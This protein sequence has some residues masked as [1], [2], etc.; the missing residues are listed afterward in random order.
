MKNASLGR[1]STPTPSRLRHEGR[2]D[3]VSRY[4][5]RQSLVLYPA[6]LFPRSPARRA[7][8]Y[9]GRSPRPVALAATSIYMRLVAGARSSDLRSNTPHRFVLDTVYTRLSEP[10]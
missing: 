2:P 4:L 9:N 5:G 10:L 7:R 6:P 3:V 1:L 8:A